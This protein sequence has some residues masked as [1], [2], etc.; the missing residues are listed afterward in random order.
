M[1]NHSN[2]K[3]ANYEPSI[4]P[5]SLNN[6]NVKL[7]AFDLN[8]LT[9]SHSLSSS[10]S[11]DSIV[12]YR[13]GI[14][15]SR[16]EVFGV[17]VTRD[18]KPDKFLR[19]SIDDGTGCVQCILWLNQMTSSYFSRRCPSDVHSIAQMANIHSSRVQIG[20]DARVRGRV[21][22]FRG[23]VQIT[24]DDVVVERDPN[25]QILHWLDCVKLARKR[26]DVLSYKK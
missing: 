18:L 20:F 9:Q 8:S 26:Y 17:V 16:V 19:F 10:S 11:R 1:S 7:L 12:F 4:N 6:I 2:K 5:N 24:V 3:P 25:Y 14:P 13:K 21:S 23:S 22:G 15:I